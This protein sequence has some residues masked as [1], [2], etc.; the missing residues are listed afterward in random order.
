[1]P[2]IDDVPVTRAVPVSVLRI[3]PVSVV[4]SAAVVGVIVVNPRGWRTHG[5]AFL[6][7]IITSYTKRSSQSFGSFSLL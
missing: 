5:V 1:L 7:V 4:K 3:A 2:V 6:V